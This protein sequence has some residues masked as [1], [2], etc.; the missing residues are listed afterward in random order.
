MTYQTLL[1]QQAGAVGLVTL[2]RPEAL[3]AI[4]TQL[5]D[6]LNQ[7]LDGFE[8]DAA[9][10][11]VLITGSAKAFAAGADVKEMAE[12]C[13]PGTYLEDFLG[14]RDRVAQRR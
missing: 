9:I 12:L 10:G 3:N 14:R 8:R 6:E 13:F 4:N 2:N 11:C 1:V 7:V 5:I